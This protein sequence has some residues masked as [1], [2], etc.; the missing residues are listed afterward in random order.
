MRTQLCIYSWTIGIETK[1][2][3]NNCNHN[4][5]TMKDS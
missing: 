2:K 3:L 5:G 1:A 4:C